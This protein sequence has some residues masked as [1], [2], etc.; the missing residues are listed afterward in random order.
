[1]H[2]TAL[3]AACRSGKLDIARALLE[4]GADPNIHGKWTASS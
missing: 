4:K 2:G 3:Q 1:M